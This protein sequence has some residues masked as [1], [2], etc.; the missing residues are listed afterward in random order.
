[1]P[2]PRPKPRPQ[3]IASRS[4]EVVRD[5]VNVQNTEIQEDK[6]Q[7]SQFRRVK[8]MYHKEKNLVLRRGIDRLATVDDIKG[9]SIYETEAWNYLMG[10]VQT[11]TTQK[12]V[13]INR[14]T[15][16]T[17]D[18]KTGVTGTG[19]PDM[20][21][22]RGNFYWVNGE[23]NVQQY[24]AP[25]TTG[26]ISVD[27]GS[28]ALTPK[29]IANDESRLWVATTE[30]LLIGS[31]I[32]GAEVTSFAT[33]GTGIERGVIASS[34]IVD[35]TALVTSGRFVCVC[36]A[37]RT[38]I[39]S[40]P[41]FSET[42]NTVYPQNVSTLVTAYENLGVSSKDAVKAVN[43]KFYIKPEDG[44]LYSITPGDPVPQ[45]IRDNLGQMDELDWSTAALEYDQA[46]NLLYISGQGSTLNDTVV[47]YNT[48][49]GKFSYFENLFARNF[50]ADKDSIYY[51]SSYGGHIEI[52]FDE[53][54]TTDNGAAIEWLIES[55]TTYSGS[56]EMYKRASRMY[57]NLRVWEDTDVLF[58]MYSDRKIDG[59]KGATYQ[60]TISIKELSTPLTERLPY[61]GLGVWGAGGVDSEGKPYVEY[62]DRNTRINKDYFRAAVVI[63]S[64]NKNKLIVQGLG[65]YSMTTNRRIRPQ[66]LTS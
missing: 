43:G 18:K 54:V 15:G 49:E 17:T 2:I 12:L 58:Q 4:G 20:A 52:A 37:N 57:L 36:G 62:Y 27:P 51:R 35:F 50:T 56:L 30:G 33:S 25:A 64:S 59:T 39:H 42:S 16:A 38:E 7:F 5:F 61:F 22:L 55:A 29:L 11:T 23:A 6:L 26:T 21:S 60:R 40:T 13:E 14:S 31:K 9:I 44:V 28:G 41:D 63:S 19:T 65:F 24:L 46:R 53:E 8:N 10:V 48:Q 45:E 1:M 32:E 47:V 66:T 34:K 3:R